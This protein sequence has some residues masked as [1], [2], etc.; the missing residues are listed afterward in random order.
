MKNYL[1]RI[2]LMIGVGL[3]FTPMTFAQKLPEG[4][5]LVNGQQ[6]I[7]QPKKESSSCIQNPKFNNLYPV[8]P[9]QYFKETTVYPFY[10]PKNVDTPADSPDCAITSIGGPK[11]YC[12]RTYTTKKYGIASYYITDTQEYVKGSWNRVFRENEEN[13]ATLF[14]LG[15]TMYPG[16]MTLDDGNRAP[17]QI[18]G[19]T[20]AV[21]KKEFECIQ[22]LTQSEKDRMSLGVTMAYKNGL[23]TEF[24]KEGLL[25]IRI[26]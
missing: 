19:G 16:F 21:D 15:N 26:K 25:F 4:C 5:Q 7:C 22:P 20:Y 9:Y 23:A 10:S 17:T 18:E 24:R 8:L 6:I 3:I 13:M 12:L 1:L 11:K 14:A 2:V